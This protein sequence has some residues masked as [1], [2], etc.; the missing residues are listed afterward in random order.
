MVM[1]AIVIPSCKEIPLVSFEEVKGNVGKAYMARDQVG[2]LL[3]ASKKLKPCLTVQKELNV[4]ATE[5]SGKQILPQLS[6]DETTI[7]ANI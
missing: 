5:Q 3:T 1:C 2:F 7:L 6:A 4:S